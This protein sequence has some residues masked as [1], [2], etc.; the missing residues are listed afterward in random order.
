MPQCC[1]FIVA[2]C[3]C[4]HFCNRKCLIV[5]KLFLGELWVPSFHSRTLRLQNRCIIVSGVKRENYTSTCVIE[6]GPL[7]VQQQLGLVVWLGLGLGWGF[8]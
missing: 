7:A 4:K 6:D 8:R 3:D 1:L 5:M 2:S